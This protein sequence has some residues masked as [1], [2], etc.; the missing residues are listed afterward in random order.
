MF[1][2]FPSK[3]RKLLH[4]EKSNTDRAKP[5]GTHFPNLPAAFEMSAEPV[6][7]LAQYNMQSPSIHPRQPSSKSRA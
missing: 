5:A 7:H 6:I 3:L 1:K 2:R 4:Q